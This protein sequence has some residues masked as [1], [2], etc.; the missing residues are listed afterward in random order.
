VDLC[1]MCCHPQAPRPTHL[2]QI[3]HTSHIRRPVRKWSLLSKAST[4][5]STWMKRGATNVQQSLTPNPRAALAVSG[6]RGRVE[7]T[8]Q[9]EALR[10]ECRVVKKQGH[11]LRGAQGDA[12]AGPFLVGCRCRGH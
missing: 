3:E 5:R 6:K 11:H 2:A 9:R 4:N 10:Q 8:P 1:E 7:R 12:L